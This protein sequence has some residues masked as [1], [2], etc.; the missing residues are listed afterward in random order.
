MKHVTLRLDEV[1]GMLYD[2]NNA[3]VATNMSLKSFEPEE[4][5]RSIHD[6]IKLKDSGFTADELITMTKEGVI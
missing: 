4:N 1:T 6:L 5:K 3:Y 2:A